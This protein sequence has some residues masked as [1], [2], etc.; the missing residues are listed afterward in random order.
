MNR[1]QSP[2]E[3]ISQNF[4]EIQNKIQENSRH[5]NTKNNESPKISVERVQ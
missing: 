5:L 1:S 2:G 3:K 4:K